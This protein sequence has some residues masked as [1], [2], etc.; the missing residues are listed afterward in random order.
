[1]LIRGQERSTVRLVLFNDVMI[2]YSDSVAPTPNAPKPSAS[3]VLAPIEPTMEA[4]GE[5]SSSKI[6]IISSFGWQ[7]H[8]FEMISKVKAKSWL[9]SFAIARQYTQH[10]VDSLSNISG[11]STQLIRKVLVQA[12]VREEAQ[13]LGLEAPLHQRVIFEDPMKQLLPHVTIPPAELVAVRRIPRKRSSQGS[14]RLSSG[15]S[16]ANTRQVVAAAA[17]AGPSL[18]APALAAPVA[19]APATTAPAERKASPAPGHPDAWVHDE[20]LATTANLELLLASQTGSQFFHKFLQRSF[21]EE[22]LA[23][24][25]A[26]ARYKELTQDERFAEAG[27]VRTLR[28]HF[29]TLIRFTRSVPASSKRA[30]RSK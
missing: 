18:A 8:E 12:K 19:L 9:K 16:G 1:M 3:V 17:L 10:R 25:G 5:S 7:L 26:V 23:F 24:L 14:I 2:F 6:S 22:N 13:R 15:I 11:C 29:L 20:T 21:C 30:Q 28:P 4:V 27:R